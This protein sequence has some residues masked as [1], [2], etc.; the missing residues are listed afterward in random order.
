RIEADKEDITLADLGHMISSLGRASTTVKKYATEVKARTIEAVKEVEKVAKKGG[1][2]EDA[3]QM[4]RS[5][6]LGIA[7]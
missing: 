1:L 3:V 5:K 7:G 6:I 2:S 4:I